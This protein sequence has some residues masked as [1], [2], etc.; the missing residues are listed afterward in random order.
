MSDFRLFDTN[1]KAAFLNKAKEVKA[2]RE[3]DAKK[4]QAILTLQKNI[5]AFLT[6][7]MHDS[8]LYP[9]LMSTPGSIDNQQYFLHF[10]ATVESQPQILKQRFIKQAIRAFVNKQ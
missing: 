5:R 7:R 4:N 9:M 10:W 3:I 2:K 6:F 8:P 1:K